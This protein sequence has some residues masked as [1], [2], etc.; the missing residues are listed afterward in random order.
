MV[1]YSNLFGH[2]A[3]AFPFKKAIK[4]WESVYGLHQYERPQCKNKNFK[5]DMAFTHAYSLPPT[6]KMT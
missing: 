4:N 6:F 3:K 2:G 5:K 1:K